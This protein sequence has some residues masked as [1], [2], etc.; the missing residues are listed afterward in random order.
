[1][2]SILSFIAL[3]VVCAMSCSKPRPTF[4]FQPKVILTDPI[5][6]NTPVYLTYP[7]YLEAYKTIQ[8]QSQ[9]A[10]QLTGMYFEEGSDIKEGQLLFTID[11]RPYKAALD[12][13]EAMLT[14][15]IAAC[16]YAQE[17][18]TRYSPLVKEEYVAQLTYDEYVT[19]LATSQS[20]VE[21]T[22]ADV[23]T[24]R[25]NLLYTTIYS[26]IQGI[27][28]KKQIDVGNYISIGES[29]P[30]IVINQMNPV[31]A[32]F[33]VPDVDLPIIQKYQAEGPLTTEVYLNQ[34]QNLKYE[35]KLTLIDNSISASTA[36]V[37]MKATLCNEENKLWPGEY[38]EVRLILTNLEN[39]LLIPSKAIQTSQEG[40][41]VFVVN[42][43]HIASIKQVR[44]GQRHGD[45][46]LIEEGLLPSDKVVLE[47]QMSLYPGLK[48]VIAEENNVPQAED[49]AEVS[50]N[51]SPKQYLKKM[52]LTQ[53]NPPLLNDRSE[54]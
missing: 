45:L 14:Q 9:I 52:R 2:R 6:Q 53:P 42:S 40:H 25:L 49:N 37:F 44:T 54:L 31:Y 32:S 20:D 39:A 34:D 19:R 27:A 11:S 5:I 22:K 28:G 46:T 29:T 16:K 1:M 18:V 12:K 8:I 24:A 26:P 21:A 30:L 47:G 35:G 10:G 50:S 43:E 17:T 4:S 7:G 36:T 38:I 33:Y 23:E 41:Y 15:S 51:L 13:A 48:V 3:S